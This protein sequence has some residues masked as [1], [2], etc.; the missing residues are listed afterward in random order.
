MEP[1]LTAGRPRMTMADV[2]MAGL[3]VRTAALTVV[4]RCL[5]TAEETTVAPAQRLRMAAARTAGLC[6]L[7][8]DALQAT[9]ADSAAAQ[10]A[11]SVE[12]AAP[13]DL[14]VVM[15]PL[16]AVDMLRSAVAATPHLEAV[17]VI[18]AEAEAIAAAV[19]TDIANPN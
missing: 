16:V 11:A 15:S 12:A 3:R 18:V 17:V 19:D 14:A 1:A 4:A 13:V 7:P 8:L 10:Q 2:P 5:R 9:A 6:R